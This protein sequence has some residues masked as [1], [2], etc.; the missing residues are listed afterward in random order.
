MVDS[1]VAWARD[2]RIDSMRF[3]LMGHQPRAAMVALQSAVKRAAGRHIHLPGEGWNFGEVKDGVR[4]VQAA[5]RSLNGTGIGAFN[6][7][8]GQP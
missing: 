8:G 7:R 5:Q 1:A 3:D 4:F 6:D 2:Y